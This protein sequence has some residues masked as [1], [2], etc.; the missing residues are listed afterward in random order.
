M[1]YNLQRKLVLAP[2][3]TADTAVS[4]AQTD[5]EIE[6]ILAIAGG[7]QLSDLQDT[8]DSLIKRN[9]IVEDTAAIRGVGDKTIRIASLA[10]S[11]DEAAEYIAKNKNKAPVSS[12]VVEFLMVTGEA[13]QGDIIYYT[14]CK[15]DAISRLEKKGIVTTKRREVYRRPDITPLEDSRPP[16]VLNPEQNVAAKGLIELYNSGT[17]QA[18]LLFGVTGSGKTLVYMEVIENVLNSG[19]T[20]LVL[21]PEISLT[22]QLMRIFTSRFGDR[23]AILHSALSVG[24]RSDEWKRIKL[25]KADL[26]LGT[27]SAVFAPLSNIGIIVIDE[28]QEHT[29]KSDNTPRYHARDVAKFRAA[30]NKSLLVLGSAT[31]SVE[32]YYASTIGRYHRFEL[33]ERYNMESL[34]DTR[35]VDLRQE[36]L[37][38]NTS[39]ISSILK[40][41][42]MRNIDAGEQSILLINRRGNSRR[43]ICGECGFMYEC[44]NCSNPLTY[45]SANGRIM[46]HLCGM[47][48]EQPEVCPECGGEFKLVGAGTQKC[49]EDL[50]ALF[51]DIEIIRMDSDTTSAKRSHEEILSQFDEKKIPILVGTQMVAK[52]LDFENV[53]LVGVIDADQSLYADDYRAHESTFSL[54]TQVVG[55]A[56]RGSKPGRAVIQTY[57]PDNPILDAAARQDYIGF[58]EGEI[59]LR[60]RLGT[61]PFREIILVTVSGINEGFALK[62]AYKARK[63]LGEL[64]SSTGLDIQTMGPHE[65]PIFKR[66]GR[67]RYQIALSCAETKL[68]ARLVSV[69]IKKFRSD[70]TLKGLSVYADLNPNQ[71]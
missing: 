26:V 7:K 54:I 21:V 19:R 6:L 13:A 62:G 16:T 57:T 17:P 32:S 4:M 20:G 50:K 46:C 9:I 63:M 29:Y 58:F 15:S 40:N 66:G 24:E 5:S 27:R 61:P 51:P 10:L 55:R 11:S 47:S 67:F 12:K 18:A 37:K 39:T 30:Y 49:E 34:P 33:T 44:D 31:P 70:K 1:W 42:L 25:G 60:E 35:I 36:L 56:G 8:A 2:G 64:T 59:E 52:G 14:G 43:M 53:T 3:L 71:M 41:E 48:T 69:I 65:A 22:P 68:S 45:H 23:I 38:A 28:E